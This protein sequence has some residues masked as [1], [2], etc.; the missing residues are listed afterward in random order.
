MNKYDENKAIKTNTEA[1][2]RIEDMINRI[3]R[4]D[5][6]NAKSQVHHLKEVLDQIN[7][8]GHHPSGL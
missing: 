6:I 8:Y 2:I 1:I 5:S 4:T 7:M 3:K